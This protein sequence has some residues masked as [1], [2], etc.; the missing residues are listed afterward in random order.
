MKSGG[1]GRGVLDRRNMK[2]M[3]LKAEGGLRAER[4]ELR[5]ESQEGRLGGAEVAGGG[6]ED[7][8]EEEEPGPG[9]EERGGVVAGGG[10]REGEV[11]TG[12]GG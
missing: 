9:G 1:G 8:E 11:L 6:G 5:T 12:L 2:D 10:E 4:L 3:K 7:A